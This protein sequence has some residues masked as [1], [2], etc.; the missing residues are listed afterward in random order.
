M[1]RVHNFCAGPAA[2][3]LEVLEQAQAEMLDWQGAGLSVMEMSHR[4][5]EIVSIAEAAEQDLRDL[6]NISDD[7]AVLFLQ[8][9]ASTQFSAIPVRLDLEQRLPADEISL[10]LRKADGDAGQRQGECRQ[11]AAVR[12]DAQ[13]L[14]VEG[15]AGLQP[16]RVPR[17]QA[18]RRETRLDRDT[19][20][21]VR[22]GARWSVA[23][24]TALAVVGVV[25]GEAPGQSAALLEQA[26][27]VT[28]LQNDHFLYIAPAS[29]SPNQISVSS[30]A[31]SV[32]SNS[33]AVAP[34]PDIR[35]S[36]GAPGR[37]KP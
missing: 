2:L 14:P 9:G 29:G 35:M 17:S 6:L 22:V 8:G 16:Q 3:P 11:G 24:A 28:N 5:A 7:Y 20:W 34:C 27:L 21:N 18:H 13:F 37:S 31:E 12:I 26:R 4:S 15:K 36:S 25:P 30:S 10:S 23:R 19:N 1:A 32:S 33:A